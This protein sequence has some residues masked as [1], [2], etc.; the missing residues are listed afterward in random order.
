VH[1]HSTTTSLTPSHANHDRG[2]DKPLFVSACPASKNQRSVRAVPRGS[3]LPENNGTWRHITHDGL[4]FLSGVLA[5]PAIRDRNPAAAGARTRAT[6]DIVE[7]DTKE[8]SR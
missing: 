5:L 7:E 8:M 3:H 1:A 2:R 6:L 4:H